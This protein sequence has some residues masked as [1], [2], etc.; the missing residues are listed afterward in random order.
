MKNPQRKATKVVEKSPPLE[1][2][3]DIPANNLPRLK[4]PVNNEDWKN[5]VLAIL[6]TKKREQIPFQSLLNYIKHFGGRYGWQ[7]DVIPDTACYNYVVKVIGI[8]VSKQI[9]TIRDDKLD[10]LP[11]VMKDDWSD[12]MRNEKAS[13]YEQPCSNQLYEAKVISSDDN[14]FEAVMEVINTLDNIFTV[15]SALRYFIQNRGSLTWK[16]PD[17]YDDSDIIDIVQIVLEVL[18]EQQKLRQTDTETYQRI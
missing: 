16:L 14:W 2:L 11:N 7:T 9:I 3:F 10:F 4:Q 8:M 18:V 15:D 12:L 17:N 13:T 5:L 1:E 6:K